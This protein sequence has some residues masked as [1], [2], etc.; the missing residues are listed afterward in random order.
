MTESVE[1]E[2]FQDH[3]KELV[4]KR[5][6]QNIES[7]PFEIL[8]TG[9]GTVNPFSSVSAVEDL[10]PVRANEHQD[11]SGKSV[12]AESMRKHIDN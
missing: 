5:E 4:Y 7:H 9:N 2:S 1:G 11:G 12:H 8:H 10:H 3:H 6:S